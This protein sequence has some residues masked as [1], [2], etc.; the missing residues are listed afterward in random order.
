[1]ATYIQI[2][3]TIT[4]GAGGVSSVTFSSIPSTYTDLVIRA[5]IRNDGASGNDYGYMQPIFNGST[6]NYSARRVL[7]YSTAANSGSGTILLTPQNTNAAT[8]NTFSNMQIYIPNY[9]SSNYKSISVDGVTENNATAAETAFC[10][11][12][13]GLW[14]Q[15]SAI[16][17]FGLQVYSGYGT[18]IQQHSTLSLYGIL[19][20]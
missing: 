14:S 3:N 10:V 11:I 20:N 4:V 12:E 6:A 16:T 15:T 13:A 5:S 18:T 2:G 9:A 1:M 19:K 17:S 7:G 8:A